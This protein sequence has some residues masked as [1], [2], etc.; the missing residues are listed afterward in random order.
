[1][2]TFRIFS[3]LLLLTLCSGCRSQSPSPYS[4]EDGAYE[5]ANN[6][7]SGTV[8]MTYKPLFGTQVTPI[9][10]NTSEPSPYGDMVIKTS[11]ANKGTYAF[12]NDKSM[13]GNWS[14]D[15]TNDQ[16]TFTGQLKDA[17]Q[18]YKVTK[19]YYS[20]TFHIKT[21]PNTRDY[22]QF[23]YTKTTK[24]P[25]PPR[26]NPNGALKGTITFMEGNNKSVLFDVATGKTG[27]IFPGGMS[28][29]N[30]SMHTV[31]L[32]NTGDNYHMQV[33]IFNSYGKT[34][35]S[36][37][38]KK[39]IAAKWPIDSYKLA[40]LNATQTRLALIGTIYTG[41]SYPQ[42]PFDYKIAVIDVSSA[43]PMGTFKVEQQRFIKPAFFKDG[44]L[45]FPP[46]EGG[47][48]VSNQQYTAQARLYKNVIGAIA[49]SPDE[50][51]IAFNE[52]KKFYTMN[53]DG[54]NV[55]QVI[56]N[57]EPLTVNDEKAVSDMTFSP[58]GKNIA[59][60]YGYG[61]SYYIIVFPLDGTASSL[62][63]DSYGEEV[64]QNNPVISWN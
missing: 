43:S 45:L 38:S 11:G 22:K 54:S 14:Y 59:L 40:L 27:K 15:A 53:A 55:K 41:A 25:K 9:F 3:F 31:A 60:T 57:G 64:I 39:I 6:M 26:P 5:G 47:I 1:M 36:W 30:P 17:L 49:L 32:T 52:G 8:T 18:A 34:V 28:S 13:S 21:G 63:K 48:A 29:T 2:S 61:P 16:L 33:D 35:S 10:V 23:V 20:L 24:T 50:K 12:I 19:D 7:S 46:A 51:I 58:D 37:N 42:F 4:L 44:R 56:C 62:I